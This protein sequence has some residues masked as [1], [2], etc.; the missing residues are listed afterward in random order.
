MVL[1]LYL[2][3]F[4]KINMA[5]SKYKHLNSQASGKG[6]NWFEFLNFSLPRKLD[7]NT[8]NCSIT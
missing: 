6:E 8:I 3:S 1:V 7:N 4:N 2:K 5:L